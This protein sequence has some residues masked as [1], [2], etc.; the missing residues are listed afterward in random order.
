MQT[1]AVGQR[2]VD[3][4]S[5]Q[6]DAA[7]ARDE[8]AFDEVAHLL[9]REHQRSELGH[10]V[11]GDEDAG[12]RVDPHLLDGGGGEDEG[13]GDGDQNRGVHRIDVGHRGV[14]VTGRRA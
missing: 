9:L 11:A 7:T 14:R 5:G 12:G 6:I 8:H 1:G 4:R 2:R 10:A 3:E 13:G